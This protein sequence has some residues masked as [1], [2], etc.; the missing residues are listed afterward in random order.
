MVLEEDPKADSTLPWQCPIFAHEITPRALIDAPID[1]G[2]CCTL[3]CLSSE[4]Q[5]EPHSEST[6][7][8]YSGNIPTVVRQSAR[9]LKRAICLDML[10]CWGELRN[11]PD[12]LIKM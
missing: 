4:L 6:D 12:I 3:R 5:W 7:V 8:H 1:W 2:R 9:R 11:S 10:P